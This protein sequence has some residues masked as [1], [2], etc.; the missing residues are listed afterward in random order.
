MSIWAITSAATT[1][2]LY[3]IPFIST[4]LLLLDNGYPSLTLHEC[5]LSSIPIGYTVAS[6]LMFVFSAIS[7]ELSAT[8]VKIAHFAMS[9][10]AFIYM[11]RIA[12]KMNKEGIT[13]RSL[14]AQFFRETLLNSLLLIALWYFGRVFWTHILR[15]DEEG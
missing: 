11:I 1:L 8:S 3:A 14:L 13:I 2:W 7:G 10:F 15:E 5:I 9:L 6:W 12:H 4:F